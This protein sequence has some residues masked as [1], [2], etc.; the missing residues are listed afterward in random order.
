MRSRNTEFK[1]Y[2]FGSFTK[3]YAFLDSSEPIIIPKLLEIVTTK[4]GDV[5]GSVG[6]FEKGENVEVYNSD[7]NR[8]GIF[9]LCAPNHKEGP[10]K[11]PTETYLSNPSSHGKVELGNEYTSSTPVIN[12]DTSI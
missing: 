5:S 11:N 3:V 8:I 2:G 9:R 12:I 4:N 10:F 1:G 7:N 6:S